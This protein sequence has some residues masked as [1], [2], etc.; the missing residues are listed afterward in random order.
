M[1]V[2]LSLYQGKRKENVT[3]N[4]N[5]VFT[6]LNRMDTTYISSLHLVNVPHHAK[7][8]GRQKSFGIYCRG[9]FEY[10]HSPVTYSYTEYDVFE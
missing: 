3:C 9:L 10:H 4:L 1:G 6:I 2:I 8:K 7:H 5:A